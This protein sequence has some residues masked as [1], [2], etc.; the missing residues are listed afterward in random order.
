MPSGAAAKARI[1]GS[2]YSRRTLIKLLFH[3]TLII[4]EISRVGTMIDLSPAVLCAAL[5]AD[6][7][8]RVTFGP[9]VLTDSLFKQETPT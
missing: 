6:L 2:A 8:T 1:A 3:L 7:Y 9:S 5:H 4:S